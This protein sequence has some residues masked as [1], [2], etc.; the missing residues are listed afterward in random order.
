MDRALELPPRG[1]AGEKGAINDGAAAEPSEKEIGSVD[2]QGNA[3]VD[4]CLQRPVHVQ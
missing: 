2:T 4:L 3:G 1:P